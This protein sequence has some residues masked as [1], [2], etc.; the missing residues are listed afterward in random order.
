M[1]SVFFSWKLIFLFYNKIKQECWWLY[2]ADPKH[3]QLISAPV[4]ICTLKDR[5]EVEV[6]FSAPKTPGDYTYWVILTSDS[7][8]DVDVRKELRVGFFLLFY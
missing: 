7:Y 2:V 3:F 6:K 1:N 4:Y 5:E 8:L